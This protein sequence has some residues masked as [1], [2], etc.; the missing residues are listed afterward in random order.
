MAITSTELLEEG[1]ELQ[2]AVKNQ[3]GQVLFGV[4]HVLKT[5]HIDMMMAWGV[6][7]ADVKVAEDSESV[8]RYLEAVQREEEALMP[9]FRRCARDNPIVREI[10]RYVAEDK[11]ENRLKGSL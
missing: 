1:M 10:I 3:Q 5:R 11:V 6:T 9:R 4:G 2:S 8:R 7:E